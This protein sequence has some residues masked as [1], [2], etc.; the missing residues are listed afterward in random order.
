MH[1]CIHS[2]MHVFTYACMLKHIHVYLH[3][4]QSYMH[5]C[6][7]ACTHAC[8]HACI[9]AYTHACTHACVQI[10]TYTRECMHT[11]TLAY[12]RA[13]TCAWMNTY[14]HVCIHIC[15]HAFTHAC[16]CIYIDIHASIHVCMHTHMRACI[17]S[18]IHAYMHTQTHTYL[19]TCMHIL[20]HVYVVIPM[21]YD[22]YTYHRFTLLW[23]ISLLLF[24]VMLFNNKCWTN[25]NAFQG[26]STRLLSLQ[27]TLVYAEPM[28]CS[29][30]SFSIPIITCVHTHIL[31]IICECTSYHPLCYSAT[32]WS[33]CIYI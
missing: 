10:Q 2:S 3:T 24:L 30:I 15:I 21:L 22:S 5:A 13:F 1:A 26:M 27:L 12:M 23:W 28:L 31:A 14:M 32:L 29:C 25:L 7:Q 4:D 33:T 11:L 17:H 20:K 16:I 9:H 6:T 19:H 18:N 8:L